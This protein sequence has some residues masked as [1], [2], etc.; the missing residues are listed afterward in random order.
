MRIALIVSAATLVSACSVVPAPA[1]TFDPTH[2]Q[3]RPVIAAVDAAPLTNRVAQLN[4]EKNEIRARIAAEP[5]AHA[6][7]RY[8]EELHSVGMELS[9]LERQLAM[10]ASAR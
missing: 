6:R 4:I 8:Y 5:D 2:P 10:Y 1:W 9:P 7:L 3:P